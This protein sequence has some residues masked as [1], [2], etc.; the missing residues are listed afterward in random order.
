MAFQCMSAAIG[1]FSLQANHLQ[2]RTDCTF[3]SPADSAH[4]VMRFDLAESE[5]HIF[6]VMQGATIDTSRIDIEESIV[7]SWA[8]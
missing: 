8:K 3:D 7:E 4:S 2:S 1:A 5:R 6:N